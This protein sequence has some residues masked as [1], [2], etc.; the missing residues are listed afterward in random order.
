M[1]QEMVSIEDPRAWELYYHH[2]LKMAEEGLF[3]IK[4]FDGYYGE[5]EVEFEEY[6]EILR[7]IEWQI[8]EIFGVSAIPTSYEVFKQ[9]VLEYLHNEIKRRKEEEEE[10]KQNEELAKEVLNHIMPCL[11]GLNLKIDTEIRSTASAGYI[12]LHVS[13]ST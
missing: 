7:F 2:V 4:K 1:S 9:K 8:K 13:R 3:K 11:S 12:T 10:R 6:R 5:F